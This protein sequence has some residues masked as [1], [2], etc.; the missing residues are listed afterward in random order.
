[1]LLLIVD[2]SIQIIERLEEL[3]SE[4]KNI[5]AI[6]SAVSYE[7]AK[8]LFGENKHDAVLLDIDLPANGSLKLLKEIKKTGW[9]PCLIML[10]T[11]PDDYVHEQYKFLGVDFFFDKY[12]DFEKINRLLC[13]VI[14]YKEKKRF[15]QKER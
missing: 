14:N 12:Y 8:K 10:G 4:E 1:M 5:T 3:I 2:S 9:K 15:G 11:H 6:H 13:S 7:E